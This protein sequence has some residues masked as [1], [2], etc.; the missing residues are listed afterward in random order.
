VLFGFP[1]PE[2]H[3]APFF[4]ISGIAAIVST[5]LTVVGQPYS[6]VE[7]GYGGLRRME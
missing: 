4:K 2:N 5:L 7:A 6:P 1:I 3:I